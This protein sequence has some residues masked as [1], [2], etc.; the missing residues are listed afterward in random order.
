MSEIGWDESVKRNQA[1]VSLNVIDPDAG[2]LIGVV[3][4]GIDVIN[5][6]KLKT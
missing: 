3:T 4:F 1:Q 2:D 6:M 5:A